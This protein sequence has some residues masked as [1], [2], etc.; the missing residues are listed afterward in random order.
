M[1]APEHWGRKLR[2]KRRWKRRVR[3]ENKGER[4]GIVCRR[5]Y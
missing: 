5:R 1:R 4:R 2:I 3:K